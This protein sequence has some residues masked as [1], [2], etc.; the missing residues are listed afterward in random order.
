M[1]GVSEQWA[2]AKNEIIK[3]SMNNII[4]NLIQFN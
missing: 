4:V 2:M 3:S 1:S